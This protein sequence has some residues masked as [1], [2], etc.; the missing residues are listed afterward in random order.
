MNITT[1]STEGTENT[2]NEMINDDVHR[3]HH[4]IAS[5]CFNNGCHARA[6]SNLYVLRVLRGKSVFQGVH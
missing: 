3:Y 6:V 2:E 4:F 5:I 1:E